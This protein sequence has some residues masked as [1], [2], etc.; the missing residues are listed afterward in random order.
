MKEEALWQSTFSWSRQHHLLMYSLLF[1]SFQ[2][3][4]AFN[5]TQLPV[6][7]CSKKPFFILSLEVWRKCSHCF[8]TNDCFF[9][10]FL[11]M[12][13]HCSCRTRTGGWCSAGHLSCSLQP[14]PEQKLT[15]Q[16]VSRVNKYWAKLPWKKRDPFEKIQETSSRYNPQP[17]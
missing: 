5:I 14:H 3:N 10:F 1:M 11:G 9:F 8:I 12:S 13:W 7:T 4:P 16:L 6:R 17:D 2:Y 15:Q